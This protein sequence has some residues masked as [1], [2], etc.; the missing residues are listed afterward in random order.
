MFPQSV[1]EQL[2]Y[3]VY[4]LRDPR[5]KKV[6]YVGK[7]RGNRVFQHVARALVDPVDPVE[8]DKLDHIR[9]IQE[10][11]TD[12][13]HILLRHGLT[14]REAF[15]IEAAAIDFV[16]IGNLANVQQGLH[17]TDFGIMTPAE[18]IARYQAPALDTK[19]PVLL[20][21]I[22][23]LFNREMT[24]EQ[25]YEATR[26]SWV[27]GPD[28]ELA[29]YAVATYRGLTREVYVIDKWHHIKD[30]RWGF[31]GKR[32]DENIRNELRYKSIAGLVARGAA[33]PIRYVNCKQSPKANSSPTTPK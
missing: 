27:V 33:N 9:A 4:F 21:N 32:A 7:G 25:I 11:G 28:R 19:L 5:D 8:S 10:S 3:Y 1:I 6:F 24:D 31:T 16:G 13:E 20:I 23:K 2:D 12:V 15:E 17:G 29:R 14:E 30:N 26:K 18:A 22:N